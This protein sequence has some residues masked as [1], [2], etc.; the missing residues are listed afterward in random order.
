MRQNPTISVAFVEAEPNSARWHDLGEIERR[1][2]VRELPIYFATF[3]I[4]TEPPVQEV[5]KFWKEEKAAFDTFMVRGK[6]C[7]RKIKYRRTFYGIHS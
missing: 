6:Q 3:I 5:L 4:S 2:A 7:D 1:R